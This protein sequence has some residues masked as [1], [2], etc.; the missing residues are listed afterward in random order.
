MTGMIEA[1]EWY[2]EQVANCRKLP[3]IPDG[4]RARQALDRDGGERARQA[5][6]SPVDAAEVRQLLMSWFYEGKSTEGLADYERG[7]IDGCTE[8]LL[9]TQAAPVQSNMVEALRKIAGSHLVRVG[10]DQTSVEDTPDLTADEAMNLARTALVESKMDWV[11]WVVRI[12]EGPEQQLRTR[13]GVYQ[14]AAFAAIAMLPFD[15]R[16]DRQIV[17]I[18]TVDSLQDHGSSFYSIEDDGLGGQRITHM[19]PTFGAQVYKL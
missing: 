8:A 17:E 14:D 11:D 13:S 10:Y 18:W 6:A 19:I 7:R 15:Q 1:L 12:N 9:R 4:E 5:L 16:D 3:G 2:A